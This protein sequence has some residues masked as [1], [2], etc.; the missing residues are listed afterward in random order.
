MGIW[1]V[2]VEVVAAT[3]VKSSADGVVEAQRIDRGA[4]SCPATPPAGMPSSSAK[5][6]LRTGPEG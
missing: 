6:R 1:S 5:A 2:R 3:Q 4:L